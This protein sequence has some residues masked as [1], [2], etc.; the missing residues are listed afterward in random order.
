MLRTNYSEEDAELFQRMRYAHPNARV[1]RRFDILWLHS[2]GKFAPE[3]ARLVSQNP[4][5]VRDVIKM[6]RDGG[7]GRVM[8]LGSNHPESELDA[9]RD[10]ICGEFRRSPPASSREAAARIEALTGIR[11]S[12]Q[13]VC[14]FMARIGMRFR[15]TAAIPAK[16]DPE[17]QEAFKKKRWSL[18]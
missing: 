6:F 3:I 8:T 7:A 9:H 13:R 5:T 17:E 4:Y 2:C 11:R 1:A 10:L 14:V 18:R 15:K 12:P 16:A